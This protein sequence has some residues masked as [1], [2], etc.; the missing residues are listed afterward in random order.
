MRVGHAGDVVSRSSC[1]SSCSCCC[2][3][4]SPHPGHSTEIGELIN[5]FSVCLADWFS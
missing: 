4:C 5:V 3:W 1:C 2:C